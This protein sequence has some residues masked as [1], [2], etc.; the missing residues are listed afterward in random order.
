[1]RKP[2]CYLVNNRD[3]DTKSAEAYGDVV[4]LYDGQPSDIFSTSKHAFAIKN[5]LKEA[6]SSD[7]LI[8]AGNMVLV[9]V[10]FGVLYEKF[11]FVNVLLYDVR[12]TQYTASGDP[13]ASTTRRL[14]D[15]ESDTSLT[16]HHEA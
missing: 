8:V 2:R 10:T 1:M 13:E 6:D 16:A 11:G 15:N 5:K 3:F 7:Y 4:T 12:S 9:L 14:T